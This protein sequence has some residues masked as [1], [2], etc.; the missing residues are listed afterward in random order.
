MSTDIPNNPDFI[1][2]ASLETDAHIDLVLILLL[3]IFPHTSLSFAFNCAHQSFFRVFILRE[4]VLHQQFSHPASIFN[5]NIP[6]L[7]TCL[8]E[9]IF[10][11][12]YSI[13]SYH[14]QNN[15]LNVSLKVFFSFSIFY[16]NSGIPF[17]AF[18]IQ[19]C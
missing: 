2:T 15:S 18:F 13:S 12:T 17:R 19:R 9:Y 5:Q 6:L 8:H 10:I 3:F 4:Y 1:V 7:S 14:Q 11:S 16:N